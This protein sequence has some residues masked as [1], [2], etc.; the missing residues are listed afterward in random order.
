M[1]MITKEKY[2]ATLFCTTFGWVLKKHT[3][4][5]GT[6]SPADQL[7]IEE[8]LDIHN[9]ARS[10]FPEGIMVSGSNEA[11]AQKTINLLEDPNATVI[12][13]ATLFCFIMNLQ[14]RS[15]SLME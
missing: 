14:G 13:E 9:R 1:A 12:F 11:S 8:G 5:E 2:L 3:P 6:R 15:K 4:A 10:L 7:R